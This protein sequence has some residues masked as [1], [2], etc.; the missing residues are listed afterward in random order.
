[1]LTEK[2]EELENMLTDEEKEFIKHIKEYRSIYFD[3]SQERRIE[4]INFNY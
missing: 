1:M 2:E 4:A 3:Y